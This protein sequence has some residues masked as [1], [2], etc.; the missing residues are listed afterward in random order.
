MPTLIKFRKAFFYNL[1][2]LPALLQNNVAPAQSANEEADIRSIALEQLAFEAG[3]WRTYW[4]ELDE[5]GELVTVLEG[6]ET[7]EVINPPN[8]YL[9]TTDITSN[10]T[11]THTFRYFNEQD[12]LIYMYDVTPDGSHYKLSVDPL[13]SVTVMD[14]ITLP[15]GQQFTMRVTTTEQRQNYIKIKQEQS[16]DGGETWQF[17]RWQH[18]ERIPE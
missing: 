16:L 18:L 6:F 2:L 3:K 5:N 13:T 17:Y 14:P 11:K 10:D 12:N 8:V 4:E 7:F 1:L 9:M 15:D